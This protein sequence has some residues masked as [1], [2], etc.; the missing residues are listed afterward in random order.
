MN[1][2]F[3]QPKPVRLKVVFLTSSESDD[4]MTTNEVTKSSFVTRSTAEND[5]RKRK[6][7]ESCQIF[8]K[9]FVD[10]TKVLRRDTVS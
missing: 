2:F 5:T 1:C 7:E 8:P 3:L 9:N 10:F 6:S 4:D